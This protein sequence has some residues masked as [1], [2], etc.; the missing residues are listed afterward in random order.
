MELV[1]WLNLLVFPN[2]PNLSTVPNSPPNLPNA[3]PNLPNASQICR[4]CKKVENC[5]PVALSDRAEGSAVVETDSWAMVD[6]PIARK[7]REEEEGKKKIDK[8]VTPAK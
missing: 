6:L 8:K 3:S 7:V 4:F 5:N 2:L 1:K